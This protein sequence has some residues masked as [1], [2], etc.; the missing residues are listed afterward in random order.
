MFSDEHCSPTVEVKKEGLRLLQTSPSLGT[1]LALPA[2]FQSLRYYEVEVVRNK[3][4]VYIGM[5]E[6]PRG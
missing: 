3:G 2:I 6:P 1:C 5:Q 4:A